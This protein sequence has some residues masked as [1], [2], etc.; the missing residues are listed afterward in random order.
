VLFSSSRN[1]QLHKATNKQF[2]IRTGG[3]EKIAQHRLLVIGILDKKFAL[4]KKN[5]DRKNLDIMAVLTKDRL[6]ISFSS[7]A[8]H[9]HELIKTTDKIYLFFWSYWFSPS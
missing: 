4:T 6:R 9:K 3:L 1:Y 2:D 5:K 8:Q 7:S